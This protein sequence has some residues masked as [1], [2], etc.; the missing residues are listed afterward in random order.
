MI[1]YYLKMHRKY[2]IVF[3][4][5][6]VPLAFLAPYKSHTIIISTTCQQPLSKLLL[7]ELVHV[8]VDI[9]CGG[10]FENDYVAIENQV[11]QYVAQVWGD[12]IAML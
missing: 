11:E 6:T 9:F 2:I 1:R 3:F 10:N 12:N 4:L 5:T 7:H 8:V